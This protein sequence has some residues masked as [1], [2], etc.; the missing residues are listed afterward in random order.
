MRQREVQQ[1]RTIHNIDFELDDEQESVEGTSEPDLSEN[2]EESLR[3]GDVL[4]EDEGTTMDNVNVEEL[5]GFY[6]HPSPMEAENNIQELKLLELEQAKEISKT[7]KRSRELQDDVHT[8]GPSYFALLRT[9][10]EEMMH[11]NQHM[12]K[13][14]MV[15]VVQKIL[16][17]K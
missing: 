3:E 1:A 5:A 12:L 16:M 9:K 11:Y 10:V 17:V 2:D 13:M 6:Q 15:A 14:E 8:M 7:N 4:I